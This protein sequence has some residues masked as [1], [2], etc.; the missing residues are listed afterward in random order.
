MTD[1]VGLGVD[2][3]FAVLFALTLAAA[4]VVASVSYYAVERP[5]LRLKR[6]VGPPPEREQPGEALAEPAP[7]EPPSTS[8]I[9]R[10]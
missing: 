2:A 5:A 9:A 8:T 4:T 1:T 3:R 7:A 10:T 6:L